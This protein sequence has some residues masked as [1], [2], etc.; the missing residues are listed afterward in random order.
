MNLQCIRCFFKA[1][2]H[3]QLFS[4]VNHCFIRR[5]CIFDLILNHTIEYLLPAILIFIIFMFSVYGLH[6]YFS[7]MMLIRS[8]ININYNYTLIEYSN[9][10]TKNVT[11]VSIV[12]FF[13]ANARIPEWHLNILITSQKSRNINLNIF[14]HWRKT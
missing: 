12:I 6:F 7:V 1:Q 8:F 3:C 5:M 4:K 2:K 11:L 14:N 13:H 10:Q 9:W